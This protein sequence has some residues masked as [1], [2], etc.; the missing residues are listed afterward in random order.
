M[1]TP[2]NKNLFPNARWG[3][4]LKKLIT[5]N[6]FFLSSLGKMQMLENF[7][8]RTCT[9]IADVRISIYVQQEVNISFF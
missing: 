7:V 9:L 3:G 5:L 2:A 1:L 6:L 4:T 8:L